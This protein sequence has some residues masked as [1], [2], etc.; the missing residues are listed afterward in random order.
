MA[1]TFSSTIVIVKTLTD[2]GVIDE[3]Y[4]RIAVGML[5]VQDMFAMIFLIVASAL[6][7][8]G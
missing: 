2:K 7:N 6:Q 8:A 3:L 1:L 5:I 4:G